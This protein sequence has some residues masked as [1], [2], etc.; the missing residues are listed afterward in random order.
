M[1]KLCNSSNKIQTIKPSYS[2][3]WINNSNSV[4]QT[5]TGI[6]FSWTIYE[7]KSIDTYGFNRNKRNLMK[8]FTFLNMIE[9]FEKKGYSWLYITS[10]IFNHFT[11]TCQY[12]LNS[13]PVHVFTK[14][15]GW[16]NFFQKI[17]TLIRYRK[18]T[19]ILMVK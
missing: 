4:S 13:F 19:M 8:K 17:K 10:R 7:K 9:W 3:P 18:F 6:S 15:I 2:P 11:L 1:I 16:N 14:S 12:H 5:G